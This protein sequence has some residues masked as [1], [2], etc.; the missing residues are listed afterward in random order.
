MIGSQA[1]IRKALIRK[2]LILLLLGLPVQ[3]ES[4][5]WSQPRGGYYTKLSGI[6]YSADEAFDGSGEKG[7]V[8]DLDETFDSQQLFLYGE[9]GAAQRFTLMGQLG[10]GDLRAKN[11]EKQ[12]STTGLGDL[13]LGA[14][15]QLT[16]GPVVLAPLVNL[17]LPTGYD[18]DGDLSL[19]TG[20]ADLEFRLL[21]AGSLHPLPAYVNVEGGFRLRG[22]SFSNQ[23]PYLFE[24]GANP[25]AKLFAKL[26][27]EG[28][29]TLVGG[30]AN[31]GAMDAMSQQVSE[32][33]FTKLGFNLALQVK[34]ALWADLLFETIF[35]GENVGAGRSLGLGFSYKNN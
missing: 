28:K 4:G 7:P 26:Y 32:G 22:G 29:N 16:D 11:R 33:D 10:L 17:K 3:V 1:L 8:D 5:A 25:R 27:V 15:Y 23:I 19:G 18:H 9:Y 12:I 14:K 21:G 35:R 30:G 31:M 2:A 6:F 34:G 20:S 13:E 24:V